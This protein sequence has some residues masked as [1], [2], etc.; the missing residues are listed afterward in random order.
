MKIRICEIGSIILNY[1]GRFLCGL[2]VSSSR[3]DHGKP[4]LSGGKPHGKTEIEKYDDR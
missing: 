1:G 3:P 2:S 4:V